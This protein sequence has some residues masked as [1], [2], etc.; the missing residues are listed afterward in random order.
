LQFGSMY[1]VRPRPDQHL[2]LA[3]SGIA[4]VVPM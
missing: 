2:G 3:I 1:E 4:Q